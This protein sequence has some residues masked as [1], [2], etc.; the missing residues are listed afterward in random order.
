MSGLAL[1]CLRHRINPAL[2]VALLGLAGAGCLTVAV[3]Q[4][5]AALGPALLATVVGAGLVWLWR[6]APV[7]P[8]PLPAL[9]CLAAAFAVSPWFALCA[10]TCLA[11]RHGR[12]R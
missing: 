7:L 6:V 3:A 11:L 5:L 10:I 4:L 8:V 1:A 12:P 9:G 2:I